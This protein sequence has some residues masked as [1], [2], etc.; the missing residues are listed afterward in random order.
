VGLSIPSRDEMEFK[1]WFVEGKNTRSKVEYTGMN[2]DKEYT[3]LMD[4]D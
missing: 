4:G 1:C 2:H 3:A